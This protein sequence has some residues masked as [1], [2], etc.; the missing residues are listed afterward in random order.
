[1]MRV[2]VADDETSGPIRLLLVD[3]HDLVVMALTAA[4][5]EITDIDVVGT[6]TS[7]AGGAALAARH[8]PDVVLLDRRLPDGDGIDAIGRFRA[9]SPRLRV[10]LFTGWADRAIADRVAA[11][12]GAGLLLKEGRVENIVDT[13]RR[14]A[15]GN[16]AF[17][18]DPTR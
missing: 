3:D 1:M 13:I 16:T 10:L 4:F 8:Q 14:V 15:A 11:A 9:E 17:D 5:E 12:G 6:A 7:V 2:P 18:V